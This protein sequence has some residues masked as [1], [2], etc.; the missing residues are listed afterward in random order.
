M[1][2]RKQS[3]PR[4]VPR[5]FRKTQLIHKRKAK[6][7]YAPKNK[8]R[9]IIKSNPISE[10]KKVEGS[11]ISRDVGL[12]L[13]GNPILNDFSDNPRFLGNEPLLDETL[14][15]ANLPT[16]ARG[17]P[18]RDSVFN[19]NPD[20]CLYQTQGIDNNS[21][22]GSSCYQ[23]MCA[24]KFLIRWPQPT[25]NTGKWNGEHDD[26][27]EPQDPANPTPAEIAAMTAWLAEP[28]NN[29][30]GLMPDAPQSYHLYWGFVKTP[31][32]YSSFT[33]PKKDEA[34]AVTLERHINLRVEEWFNQRTD[35]ISFIPKTDNNLQIIGKKKL[36]PPWDSRNGRLPVSYVDDSSVITSDILH[37]GVIPDTLVKIQWPINKKIHFQETNNFSG[38]GVDA[39]GNPV[40]GVR[41]FYG[42]HRWLPF[43]CI[44]N[45][46]ANTLPQNA[47][48][49]PT[50]TAEGA[51]FTEAQVARDRR[52][53]HVLVNDI[54]YYRDS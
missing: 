50:E 44:V 16:G 45:W 15:I 27:P 38:D 35:R 22:I 14:P 43:A 31:T 24:A 23:R 9:F 12:N 54:T 47:A 3:N 19:F 40:S 42:N 41:T 20:S 6:K 11:E 53:P 17:F 37:E 8:K 5:M 10:N 28:R 26:Y 46:N 48:R 29:H 1:A 34:D 30:M 7:A 4:R 21:L 33:N 36:S 51:P 52:V 2:R 32:G 39:A 49:T 25:M 13:L 18:L